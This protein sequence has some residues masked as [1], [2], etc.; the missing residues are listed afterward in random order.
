MKMVASLSQ[1]LTM[2]NQPDPLEFL[3]SNTGSG[4]S[5]AQSEDLGSENVAQETNNESTGAS[6]G[7]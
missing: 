4:M 3:Y 7:T 1:H 2:S 5:T 6:N